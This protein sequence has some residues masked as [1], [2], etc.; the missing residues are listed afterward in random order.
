MQKQEHAGLQVPRYFTQEG[1]HPFDEIEWKTVDVQITDA[2]GDTTFE[3]KGFEA[4]ASWE[5]NSIRIVAQKYAVR[6]DGPDGGP[7]TSVKHI[8]SRVAK[9]FRA[10]GEEGGYFA[11]EADAQA[12]EDELLFLL[13]NQ[14]YAPNSPVW[15]NTGRS[16]VYGQSSKTESYRYAPESQTLLTTDPITDP[17]MS[18]CFIQSVEDTIDGPHGILDL[19]RSEAK[20]FKR[21]SGTGSNFSRIRG[22]GEPIK[23]GG[24]SSGLISFLK[25][26]DANAGSVK[27]GGT[28]RRAAKMVIVDDDHPEVLDFITWKANEEKKAKILAAAGIGLN[29]QGLV[30]F[31]GEAYT[32][33][34]G[35]NSNN[36]VKL[37]TRFMHQVLEGGDWDLIA[38]TTGEVMTTIKAQ[39]M[40]DAI[41]QCAWECADP[42]VFFD[43]ALQ[44][45]HTCKA[46]GPIR[47]S[48][49]CAEYLFLD[50]T[51][52]NLGSLNLVHFHDDAG[53]LRVDA[54][55]AAV[56]LSIIAKE[57]VVYGGSFPT[58]DIAKGTA[59]YRTLGL[60]YANV[61]TL[62][63]LKGLG[64]GSPEG[65]AYM[66]ALTAL[67]TSE[68]Y[69]TSAEMSKHFGPFARYEANE[70]S[71]LDVMAMHRDAAKTLVEHGSPVPQHMPGPDVFNHG[72]DKLAELALQNWEHVVEAGK[73]HGFRNAQVV[74]IAPTGTIGFM[75][76][77]STTGIEPAFSL[78]TYKT[79]AGGGGLMLPIPE[80]GQALANLGYEDP[81][82]I[83]AYINEHG[84]I[85]GAPGLRDEHVSVFATAV[86]PSGNSLDWKDH[87]FMTAA[88]QPFLSGGVSKTINMPEDV[89]PEDI[90]GAYLLAWRLGMKNTAIYRDGSKSAQPMNVANK[91]AKT[92][93]PG[94]LSQD[95]FKALGESE[96]PELMWG[97]KEP[98]PRK[99]HHA[100]NLYYTVGGVNVH[101]GL[102]FIKKDGRHRLNQVFLNVGDQGDH[103]FE[104]ARDLAIGWSRE[105][106]LGEKA[107]KIASKCI[108]SAGQGGGLTDH[109]LIK[110]A[111]SLKDFVWKVIALEVYGNTEFVNKE[112][113]DAFLANEDREPFIH[114]TLT[115]LEEH[116]QRRHDKPLTDFVQEDVIEIQGPKDDLQCPMCGASEEAIVAT[117]TCKTC[118]ACGHSFGGC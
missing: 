61:G 18:A 17:Q 58:E 3:V 46:D 68:A 110:N 91:Q 105:L 97:Y 118:T 27:S 66:A 109:P 64:Y 94:I 5:D 35:Q 1:R 115:M 23:G 48:N 8:T 74:V 10:M 56:R 117:G 28:T 9:T 102:T 69:L 43:E 59:Q 41:S 32:T 49:P 116:L 30:D 25:I 15:F 87:L 104:H 63:M 75:M 111:T 72:S 16:H 31:E 99:S 38:R 62:L 67:M 50:N 4:P 54:F 44:A 39:D 33:V 113:L 112:L 100:E 7:E 80:V 78:M 19:V 11:S 55:L 77:C 93:A 13:V 95:E 84:S 92:V 51:S 45:W 6:E 82:E 90:Q 60:G 36:S 71:M 53:E 96:Y 47:S 89:T 101:I 20:L 34:S 86:D 2:S 106:R 29:A 88:V 73:K 65:R 52:C 81:E 103:I 79:L 26:L 14:H 42:G 12:F 98:V 114:E 21:G 108:N 83:L 40:F 37:S 57:L 70:E 22:I 85:V 76:G 107:T 24:V